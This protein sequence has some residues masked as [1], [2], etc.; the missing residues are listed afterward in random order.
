MHSSNI[1]SHLPSIAKTQPDTLAVA[2]QKSGKQYTYRELDDA[3]DIIAKGLQETGIGKGVRTVLMV[4][5]SLDFFTL[6]FALFKVG[7][8]MII[9]DPGI[10]TKQLGKCLAEA[11]PE[12]FIGIKKAHIARR[13]FGWA[14]KTIKTNIIV[15]P[16]F[17]PTM[18]YGQNIKSLKE[19][20][21][22]G[23]NNSKNTS[24]DTKADDIAAILF[25]SGSTGTPKGVIY[26][27]ENFNAQVLTLKKL[28]D[29]Q[30]GEND[31]S[32]FPLFALFGP[33][34]GMTSIVPDM[35][36]TRPGSVDPKII[37]SAIEKYQ[38]TTMFGSPALLNRV[39]RY[40]EQHNKKLPGL[41]R[42]LS[43]GAPVPASVVKRFADML[44]DD[45]QVFTPYGATESLPVSSIS[46][47]EVLQSTCLKTDEGKGVCVGF[48]VD[49]IDVKII[50]ICNEPIPAWRE[51]LVL[52]H[53]VIGEIVVKGPQVTRAYY[54]RQLATELA[55]IIDPAGGFY[56]RM[57]DVGYLDEEGRLWFCGRLTH[58][59]V[60]KNE[61]LFTIPCEGIYNTHPKVFRTALVGAHTPGG[62]NDR[63]II[64]VIC[65]E[66]EQKF[67]HDDQK[68]I[69]TELLEIGARFEQTN[70][71]Q[72][73]LFHPAFP[74]DIRHNAKIGREK[75]AVWSE[76]Q[77]NKK[78]IE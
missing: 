40:G 25:T 66:L 64:P 14:K 23:T 77:I 20:K 21:Q 9:I 37:F 67:K 39:G 58:R 18:F 56:H 47:D 35:D 78:H 4:T 46:S 29:I 59:V 51:N 76:T 11:E 69:T 72:H 31:L 44:N 52:D 26:T 2:E 73:I 41:K 70:S 48:P 12:A 57:G 74:V 60:T 22:L 13:I 36:F 63:Q 5:P 55:K 54:A 8:V 17:M 61:T 7:A 49:N 6:V 10:G 68:I 33:A 38:I 30:A 75:L 34:M 32:T 71:I 42:V 43:A 15:D 19:L 28:Y 53:N 27:H 50:R 16:G 65:V 24:V 45:A 1:A 3:S 62:N